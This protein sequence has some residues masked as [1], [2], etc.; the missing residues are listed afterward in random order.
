MEAM[1]RA[2]TER[3]LMVEMMVM[4]MLMDVEKMVMLMDVE[5]WRR[6]TVQSQ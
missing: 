1:L 2:K 3:I 6:R 4:V 5:I